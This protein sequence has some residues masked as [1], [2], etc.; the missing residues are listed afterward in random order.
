MLAEPDPKLAKDAPRESPHVLDPASWFPA[1]VLSAPAL[2]VPLHNWQW[3]PANAPV[4]VQLVYFGR[5]FYYHPAWRCLW[6][7]CGPGK[8][9][10]L[11]YQAEFTRVFTLALPELDPPGTPTEFE[12]L[13]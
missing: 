12:F 8:L 1:A 7:E 2:S 6:W 4:C 13:H 3:L 11:N 10:R 9:W 5:R